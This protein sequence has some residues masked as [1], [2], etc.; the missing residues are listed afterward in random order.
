MMSRKRIIV[1]VGD[2]IDKSHL[3]YASGAPAEM[4][5]MGIACQ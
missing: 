1:T 2:R 4:V 3:T 5:A